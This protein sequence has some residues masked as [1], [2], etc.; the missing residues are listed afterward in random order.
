MALF[1]ICLY[2]TTDHFHTCV[3]CEECSLFPFQFLAQFSATLSSFIGISLSLELFRIDKK[4]K[5]FI[6]HLLFSQYDA[7]RFQRCRVYVTVGCP[8]HCL[9]VPSIAAAFR[10]ISAAGAPAQ[11]P[12]GSVNAVIPGGST[13]T[14][15]IFV[16][17]VLAK[18]KCVTFKEL[19]TEL[20]PSPALCR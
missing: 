16:L 2:F 7:V 15:F 1:F 13:Q 5:K 8:S 3:L 17:P 4:S 9:S 10:S 12:A 20:F 19:F 11:Q 18:W 6:V 14:C